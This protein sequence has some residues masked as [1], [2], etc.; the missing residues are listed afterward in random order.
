MK[1]LKFIPLSFT[2]IGLCLVL[3]VSPGCMMFGAAPG[4]VSLEIKD[5][6]HFE[7]DGK[8]YDMDQMPKVVKRSGARAETE[9][10]V[11]IPAHF[12]RATLLPAYAA[13]QKAGFKKTV[14]SGPRE[15]TTEIGG[16][17]LAPKASTRPL[18][19]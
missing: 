7:M 1:K 18:R 17:S 5:P 2:G 15:V 4:R 16:N 8:T 14:F 12:P 19:K 3:L 13:M 6:T 11:Q 9:I 10:L